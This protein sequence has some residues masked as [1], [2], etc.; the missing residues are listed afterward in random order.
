MEFLYYLTGLGM[1]CIGLY[2]MI[3]RQNLLKKIIGLNI[4]GNGVHIFLIATG[5]RKPSIPPILSAKVMSIFPTASVD[6]IPQALVLTSI[7]IDFSITGLAL[8]IAIWTYRRFKTLDTSKMK[9][10]RY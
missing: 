2:C 6:P 4:L 9:T 10:L 7:V 5:Y 3:F 1:V 8:M